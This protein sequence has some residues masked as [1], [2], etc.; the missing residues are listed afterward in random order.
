MTALGLAGNIVQFLDF[1]TK[2]I[3]SRVELYTSSPGT[4]RV[5]DELELIIAEIS[6]LTDTLSSEQNLGTNFQKICNEASSLAG[7]IRQRL[8]K[9]KIDE[10]KAE[11]RQLHGKKAEKQYG[12]IIYRKWESLQKALLAAWTADEPAS[13]NTRWTD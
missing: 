13:L 9:I 8:E 2:L 6:A 12:L 11:E 10:I 1:G 3:S 5:S 7:E 4:L